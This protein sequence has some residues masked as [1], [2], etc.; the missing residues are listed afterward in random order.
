[1]E[2]M[3][4]ERT[5]TKNIEVMTYEDKPIIMG[6]TLIGTVKGFPNDKRDKM[7]HDHYLVSIAYDNNKAEFDFYG[8]SS[9]Y[10]KQNLLNKKSDLL[11]ALDC[12]IGDSLT[13]LMSFN[14]FCNEFGYDEDSRSAERIHNLC[15]ETTIK[16]MKL[17]FNE[18]D[19]Y[20]LSNIIH[21]METD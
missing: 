16:T 12:F 20:N 7:Y 13:G 9:D 14:D 3:S 19:L 21:D 10:E 1:V 4:N 2:K 5:V 18:S 15:K 6:N 11:N 17:G 8:S